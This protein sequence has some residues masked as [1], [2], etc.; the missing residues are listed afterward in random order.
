MATH[1]FWR[2]RHLPFNE[3]KRTIGVRQK[4]ILTRFLMSA[5]SK[6]A[7]VSFYAKPQPVCYLD[8]FVSSH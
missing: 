5:S 8:V 6:Q 3:L 7:A 2:P 1:G 4:K